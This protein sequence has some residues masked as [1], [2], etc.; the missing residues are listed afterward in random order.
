MNI[1]VLNVAKKLALEEKQVEETLKLLA[2]GA[3]IPF[4]SRYRKNVTG[5]LDEEAIAQ[6]NDFYQYDV[7]LLKRKEYV[8][9]ILKE[10]GLLTDEL[11]KKILEAST[12]QAV[13]NIYEPFKIGKKTKATEA[14]A[15]GLEPLAKTIMQNRDESFNVFKEAAKYISEKLPNTEAVIGQTKYIIAQIISQDIEARENIKKEI[16]QYGWIKTALKKDAQDPKQVFL[17]YYEFGEK[18]SKIPN[19]RILAIS[20]AEDKKII[21]YTFDYS[22]KKLVYDL[23]NRYFVNKRTAFITNDCARDALERLILPSID[24]EI[25]SE[26]FERAQAEAIKIFANN[27]EQMLLAPATK[28]K[29]IL[30]ID[31]A[32]VHGCKLAVLDENG[33]FL[34]KGLIFP[35]EPR[36]E[37]KN[38]TL[39]VNG[40]LDKYSIDL[41]VIG[42][43][44]ASRET[45]QFI[46]NLLQNRKVQHPNENI[47]FAVVSEIGASVYSASKIA[48]EEFPN[49]SV[50]ERSAINIGRR[51]QDPLNE[52]IKIEPKSIGVGQYQHDVNQKELTSELD[53]KV[54]KV[55]NMVGV[56]LNSATKIILSHIS[57]LSNTI[58]KNIVE[59][60]LKNGNFKNREELKNVKG[61]GPKAYEQSVGFLRIHDSTNFYDK[62]NIHPDQYELAN[63]VLAALNLNVENL[64]K[65]IL[66]EANKEKLAK[67]LNTNEYDISL[68]LDS[69][70]SPGKDI[71][72]D[73]DG[74]I[75]SD[76]LLTVDDLEIGKRYTGQVIN[77]TDF[78][79]FFF[80]GIKQSALVH[81][82]NMKKDDES[83][84][85]HP[86]EILNVGENWTIEIISIDKERERIQAK[87][88]WN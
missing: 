62:T 50:E 48:Q 34:E 7:E 75:L 10:K 59:H 54:N 67:E 80:L 84:I 19:H 71:R 31:P 22:V 1:S 88:I 63:K 83:F 77:V 51:F 53:F 28:N 78:G 25:K 20:R 9:E 70:I 36:S 26:L 35:N 4:I 40:L 24:R 81:I 85:K 82:S 3:T 37:I 65:N 68:I 41:I 18:I 87:L 66:M 73:K 56:D 55:V 2:E 52:L 76:K 46:S 13:E 57:G 79:A 69:L 14:I 12:K 6:I 11:N 16:Y 29:K 44:T 15:L 43:G 72:D 5:G 49:L 23:S 39:R 42:N 45:E 17:Q 58:A 86:S 21:S 60:R 30:A 8:I 32:Y 47:R 74:F 61:L 38:A 33:N 64:D 27:V